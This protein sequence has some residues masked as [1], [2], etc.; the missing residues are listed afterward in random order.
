MREDWLE[1][2]E[3]SMA[4]MNESVIVCGRC[5]RGSNP[6]QKWVVCRDSKLTFYV[7]AHIFL[8]SML[9]LRTD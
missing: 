5:D 7:N 8:V 4:A 6:S 1:N 9:R 2:Q 3:V